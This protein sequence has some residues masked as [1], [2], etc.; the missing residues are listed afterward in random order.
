MK[1]QTR[2]SPGTPKPPHSSASRGKKQL[3]IRQRRFI[4]GKLQGRS[5]AEAARAAGY[6][7]SVSRHANRIISE[8][9][10]IQAAMSALLDAAGVSN[11][12]LAQRMRE[13]L[14]ATVVHHETANSFREVLVDFSERREMVELALRVK[15]LLVDRHQVQMVKT[16]EEILEESCGERERRQELK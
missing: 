12:L 11:E 6:S 8:S 16:L 10:H 7:A 4:E 15:G 9:P 1:K 3:T 5:S 13:G 2:T 14:D